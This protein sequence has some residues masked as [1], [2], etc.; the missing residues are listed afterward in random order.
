MIHTLPTKVT[1]KIC[2]NATNTYDIDTSFHN[3]DP[4]TVTNQRVNLNTSYEILKHRLII[5]SS[6]GSGRKIDKIEDIWINIANY[7]PLSGS[8]FIPLP[9]ELNNSMKGLINL[10]KKDTECFK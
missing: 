3:S 7:D 5:Y 4:I 8:S 1:L 9:P 10:K 6:E 2:N